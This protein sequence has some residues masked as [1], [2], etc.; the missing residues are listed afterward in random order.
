[1][2]VLRNHPVLIATT[3][4]GAYFTIEV[5]PVKS[6]RTYK[7]ERNLLFIWEMELIYCKTKN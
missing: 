5:T 2:A 4:S 7:K 3:I 1:M 6:K